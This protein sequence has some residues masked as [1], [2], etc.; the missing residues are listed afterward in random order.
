M[1]T[2]SVWQILVSTIVMLT[3]AASPLTGEEPQGNSEYQ[4]CC[5]GNQSSWTR[6]R[7]NRSYDFKEIETLDGKVI[8]L[9]TQTSRIGNFQGTHF[10][11]ETPQETIEVQVAPSWYL[12]EQDF[13]INT[14]EKVVV[15]GSRINIGDREAIIAREIKKG[16]KTLT[17]RDANG[18]PL[19]RRGQQ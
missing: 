15:I 17:L 10:M 1:N 2:K 18:F 7:N 16:D 12:A 5:Q 4:Y 6:G 3:L 9:N 11:I 8:S 13:D 14:K 19:W